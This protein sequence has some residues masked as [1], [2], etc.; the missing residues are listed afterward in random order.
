[1]LVEDDEEQARLVS[2]FLMR[3]NYQVEH[4]R[5]GAQAMRSMMRTLPDIVILDLKLP[6]VS[7]LEVLKWMRKNFA[8]VPAIVLSNA[9]LERDAVSAF[10]AGADD[11]V[12]KPARENEFLARMAVMLRRKLDRA[13]DVIEI[14]PISVDTRLKTVFIDSDAVKLTPIEYEI[15]ELLARSV[16]KV[17]QR[18]LIVN[19]IWGRAMDEAVSRSLDTHVYRLRQKLNLRCASGVSLRSVYTLGYRLK[20]PADTAGAAGCD[21]R[22]PSDAENEDDSGWFAAAQAGW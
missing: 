19:R 20:F 6:D 15:F 8:N 4:C 11:F 16:G 22:M 18:E 9:S 17:V 13:D 5:N 14:G 7:G 3:A 12:L 1:M 21:G 10:A 2:L